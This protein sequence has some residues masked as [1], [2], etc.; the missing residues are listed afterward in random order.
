[1]LKEAFVGEAPFESHPPRAV[2]EASIRKFERR[3]RAV[4]YMSWFAVAFGGVV[5]IAALARFFQLPPDASVKT[6]LIYAVAF[7]WG[8][9]IVGMSK[10]W[11]LMMIND[12]GVR[13]EVKRIQL[14]L[15]DRD[16]NAA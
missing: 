13:K 16:E 9:G 3:M 12:I 14:M 4:R 8:L 6:L 7:L 1:M 5:I 2:L 11:L 15:I 10:M